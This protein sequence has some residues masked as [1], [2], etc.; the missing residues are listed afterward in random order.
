MTWRTF[1]RQARAYAEAVKHA[2][3]LRERRD[4][5][6]LPHALRAWVRADAGPYC[7][8]RATEIS[9]TGAQLTLDRRFGAGA[10]VEMQVKFGEDEPYW[11]RGRV[12]WSRAAAAGGYAIGVAFHCCVAVDLHR[13]RRWHH[14]QQLRVQR[15]A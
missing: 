9:L 14:E 4:S 2:S 10:F 8:A 12:V 6:R 11:L 13:L 7:R 1:H 15:P 3:S 5:A